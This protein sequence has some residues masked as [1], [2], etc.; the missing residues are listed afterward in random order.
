M[1]G[2]AGHVVGVVVEADPSI[3]PGDLRATAARAL[4]AW[5]QPHVLARVDRMPRLV[6]G[7]SD[8]GACQALLREMRGWAEP[9]A[10]QA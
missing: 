10:R 6:S 8:R 2:P 5:L 4:P 3:V 1:L 7:K 9:G